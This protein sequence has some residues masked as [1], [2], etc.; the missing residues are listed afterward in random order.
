ML[1]SGIEIST[2]FNMLARQVDDKTLAEVCNR[3]YDKL[4]KGFSM[5]AAMK[6]EPEHFPTFNLEMIALAERSGKIASIL[7]QLARFEEEKY[8]S[9]RRLKST[10][11]YP[12]FLGIAT[13][14]ILIFAPAFFVESFEQTL[15][16]VDR[17]MPA[18]AQA[19]FGLS[20]L[21]WSFQVWALGLLL[22]F[23]GRKSL[24]RVVKNRRFQN[25]FW[26]AAWK[27][28]GL[29]LVLASIARERFAR[30]L[31]IQ[32][33]SGS[34]LTDSLKSAGQATANPIFAIRL[35]DT[36]LSLIQG[37]DVCSALEE[38][39]LFDR[40]LLSMVEVG[41]SSGSLPVLMQR[42]A[43][44]QAESLD[45]ALET[46]NSTLEPLLMTLAGL[47]V[48]GLVLSLML[49]MLELFKSL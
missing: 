30:A 28:P 4:L 7:D 42:Y 6:E 48:G 16:A 3:I 12:C 40:I 29:H 14:G 38:T 27:V 46:A 8:K 22:V 21:A 36:V 23:L 13:L 9:T 49:P 19:V 1:N 18:F 20:K 25:R 17:Q 34:T 47:V 39:E 45:A 43:D 41:V 44:M 37:K 35:K 32:L 26:R 31:A 10:L 33:E 11:V 15:A 2:C 24:L 5:S